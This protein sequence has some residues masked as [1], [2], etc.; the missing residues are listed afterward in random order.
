[1]TAYGYIR[2]S[3]AIEIAN[4]QPGERSRSQVDMG[5]PARFVVG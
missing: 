4:R 2:T 1:M 5:V 3:D